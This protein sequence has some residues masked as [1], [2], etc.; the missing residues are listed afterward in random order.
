MLVKF[1]HFIEEEH[2]EKIAA[3]RALCNDTCLTHFRNILYGQKKQTSLDRLIL[4][5][6]ACVPKKEKVSDAEVEN[7]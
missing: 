6:P 2:S 4:Q 5:R 3:A 7:D 1:S